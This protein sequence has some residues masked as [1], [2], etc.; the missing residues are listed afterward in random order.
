MPEFMV[1]FA[2]WVAWRAG[3]RLLTRRSDRYVALLLRVA[4]RLVFA[5]TAD[6]F[7][8]NALTELVDI[9]EAGGKPAAT[10]RLLF[11]EKDGAYPMA[12]IR[13]ALRKD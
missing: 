2:A 12:V 8:K 7:L 1:R 13:G 10:A 9:F 11:R 4:R 3:R 5:A 6:E